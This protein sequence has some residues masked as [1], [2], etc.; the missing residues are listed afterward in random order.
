MSD[1]IG[2]DLT[3]KNMPLAFDTLLEELVT[4]FNML[5]GRVD[6]LEHTLE[7]LNNGDK[8]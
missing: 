2:G 1:E 6:V 3:T 8:K 5:V 7:Q 4:K